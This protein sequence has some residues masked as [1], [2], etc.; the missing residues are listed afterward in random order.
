M[1]LIQ[2]IWFHMWCLTSRGERSV[3]AR[4]LLARANKLTKCTIGELMWAYLRVH[5]YPKCARTLA[6]QLYNPRAHARA[7]LARAP[8]FRDL[9]AHLARAPFL[10][11]RLARVCVKCSRA[12]SCVISAGHVSYVL[13][14]AIHSLHSLHSLQSLQPLQSLFIHSLH[15][16]Y[17]FILI[18]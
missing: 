13:K 6:R 1:G 5:V 16:L 2:N 4:A 9:L 15:S 12:W 17:F 18:I 3:S 11:A 8:C 7:H 10:L 14:M